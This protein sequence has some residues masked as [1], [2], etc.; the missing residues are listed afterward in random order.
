MITRMWIA[1]FVFVSLAFSQLPA[2]VSRKALID[3]LQI[4]GMSQRELLQL[5]KQR[6]VEFRLNSESEADLRKNG[7]SPEL[8][9]AVKTGYRATMPVS[10]ASSPAL[11]NLKPLT[12]TEVVTLLHAGTE[13]DRIMQ[14]A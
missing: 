11:T 5:V 9:Q 12:K 1:V 7:A 10:P 6:G 8:V 13:A 14:V 4:G 3:A 2:P